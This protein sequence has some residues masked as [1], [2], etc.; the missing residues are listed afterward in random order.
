MLESII[1]TAP[2]SREAERSAAGERVAG[3][4][5]S[6]THGSV[7]GLAADSQ[8]RTAARNEINRGG[9]NTLKRGDGPLHGLNTMPARQAF[10]AELKDAAACACRGGHRR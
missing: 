9:V 2:T 8:A 5:N 1:S 6:P 10:D 3:G 7:V 4:G